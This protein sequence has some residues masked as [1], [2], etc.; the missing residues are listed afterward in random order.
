VADV[1]RPA[2]SKK[3]SKHIVCNSSFQFTKGTLLKVIR[4]LG[5]VTLLYLKIE[6]ASFFFYSI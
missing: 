6:H 2:D 1:N 4:N 3:S 5:P